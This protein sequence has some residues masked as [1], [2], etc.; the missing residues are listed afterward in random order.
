MS[1][2]FDSSA[3]L[4]ALLDEPG[5]EDAHDAMDLGHM[6]IINWCEVLSKF[7][8]AEAMVS[9]LELRIRAFRD[10]HALEAARLRSMTMKQGLSFGD[11]ACLAHARLEQL[12]VITADRRWAELDL[13]IDIRLLR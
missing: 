2:L 5:G 13:G 3:V 4:A 9:R 8:A 1:F 10:G 11:R 12:P 7:D 6:S